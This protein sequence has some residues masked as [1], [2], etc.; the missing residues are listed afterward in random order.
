MT[1]KE[2]IEKYKN[3]AIAATAD[4]GLFPSVILAMAILET[5][6][7]ESILARKYNNFFGIKDGVSWR[8]PTVLIDTSE[9]T[10]GGF[11]DVKQSFRTYNDPKASFADVV[12]LLTQNDIYKDVQDTR[13]PFSQSKAIQA[14][15]YAT[16]PNYSYKLNTI[17][18]TQ[19]LEVLDEKKNK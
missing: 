16:D 9:Y 3:M 15:G 14:A 8:G 5:N 11:S 18:I 12:R 19:G 17:I 10:S 2:F 13:S 4:T 7:G 6:N 1:R